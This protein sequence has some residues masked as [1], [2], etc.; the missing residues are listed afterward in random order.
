MKRFVFMCA[1]CL[2]I[3]APAWARKPMRPSA[4]DGQDLQLPATSEVDRDSDKGAEPKE[5][6]GLSS[7]GSDGSVI[8]VPAPGA[9]LLGGIGVGLIGWLRRRRAL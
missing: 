6:M 8:S 5:E 2:L 4:G 1:V 3:A 7:E 9:V